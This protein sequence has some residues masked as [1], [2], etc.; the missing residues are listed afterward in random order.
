MYSYKQTHTNIITL[1][2][3]RARTNL[4]QEA[5]VPVPHE[6]R[7]LK[8]GPGWPPARI[9]GLPSTERVSGPLKL[10]HLALEA[11]NIYLRLIRKDSILRSKS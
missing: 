7:P 4:T 10:Y 11:S 5:G 3:S 9:K 1:K 2:G 6:S 8:R